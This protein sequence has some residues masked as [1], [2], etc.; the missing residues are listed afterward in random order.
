MML[1]IHSDYKL[2]S[3]E[4]FYGVVLYIHPYGTPHQL[5]QYTDSMGLQTGMFTSLQ[6]ELTQVQVE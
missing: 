4:P 3:Y 5:V 1:N 6:I 2:I